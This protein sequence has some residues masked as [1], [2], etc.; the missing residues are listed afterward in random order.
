[1]ECDEA[2]NY[3]D[4]NEALLILRTI[5]DEASRALQDAAAQYEAA[6]AIGQLRGGL[7]RII[8]MARQ[9]LPE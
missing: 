4:R 3:V 8:G 9:E 6:D 2:G 7:E 5:R 1:M